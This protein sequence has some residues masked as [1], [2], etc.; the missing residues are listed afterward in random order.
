MIDKFFSAPRDRI[1]RR[2]GAVDPATCGWSRQVAGAARTV[3]RMTLIDQFLQRRPR[4]R[5]A[6]LCGPRRSVLLRLD[7]GLHR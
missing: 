3:A 7:L 4:R 6:R 5:Q 2:T 1:G